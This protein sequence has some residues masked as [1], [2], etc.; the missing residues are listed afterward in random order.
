MTTIRI[1][2]FTGKTALITGGSSGI[3]LA[4]AR[5]LAEQGAN[6]W[7]L[8]RRT[9][10]LDGAVKTLESARQSA[11]QKFGCVSA[12]VTDPVCV[13]QVMAEVK[14]V[15]GVPD[16]LVNSAGVA[17]GGY[18]QET[19]MDLFHWMMDVDFYGTV[20]VIKAVLPDMMARRSGYI[21]NISSLAAVMGI[22]G[23]SA[24]GAAKFAVRG[25]SES[26]RAEMKPY[27]IGVSI[28]YPPDTDTP[29]LAYEIQFK[30][31][32]TKA[33][34]AGSGVMSPGAVA[35]AILKGVRRG[36]FA[37]LPGFE[38]K[39]LYRLSSLFG[40]TINFAFDQTIAQA[41]HKQGVAGEKKPDS[42]LPKTS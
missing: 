39:L 30:P 20:H 41:Q 36:Q 7:I 21:V 11:Q 34:S 37:I 38:G 4:I 9:E 2:D 33:L 32:E 24:Y 18:F 35:A 17:Q 3:G 25:F 1:S 26:L 14:E 5:L 27:Q 31:V 19:G 8:A 28:A 12:D 16:L 29:Q 42:S 10:L 15:I 40:E 13:N 22:F 6:V 23:Y